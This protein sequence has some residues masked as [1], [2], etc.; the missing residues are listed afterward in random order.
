[1]KILG[2][3]LGLEHRNDLSPYRLQ[4]DRHI[5]IAGGG[6][7]HCCEYLSC[8][9][10]DLSGIAAKR[11]PQHQSQEP[12]VAI[13]EGGGNLSTGQKQLVS[14]ARAVLA[15]PKIFVMDEATSSVDTET[16]KLI[17]DGLHAVLAGRISIIIAHRLSTIRSADQILVIDA[18]RTIEQGTHHDLI[19]KRG[20]YYELYTQQF[21]EEKAGEILAHAD[22]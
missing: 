9:N 19:S 22:E 1:V 18:G 6:Q 11:Q 7:F 16:E 17:Q 14:F 12:F 3:I 13:G 2:F 5:F 8:L 10:L 4:R 20:R 15:D 21:T